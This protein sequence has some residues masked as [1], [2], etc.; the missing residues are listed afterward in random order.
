MNAPRSMTIRLGEA[1]LEMVRAGHP[2]LTIPRQEHVTADLSDPENAATKCGVLAS[3]AVAHII[4]E[5]ASA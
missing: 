5:Q 2:D 4:H 1:V 3:Q